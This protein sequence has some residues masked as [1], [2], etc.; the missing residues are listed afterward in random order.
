[1]PIVAYMDGAHK[2]TQSKLIMSTIVSYSKQCPLTSLVTMVL[3]FMRAWVGPVLMSCTALTHPVFGF[4]DDTYPPQKMVMSPYRSPS[5]TAK[6]PDEQI[7]ASRQHAVTVKPHLESDMSRARQAS[8]ALLRTNGHATT[9]KD[10][11]GEKS[12]AQATVMRESDQVPEAKN[13]VGQELAQTSVAPYEMVPEM[14]QGTQIQPSATVMPIKPI[15][16][17]GAQQSPHYAYDQIMRWASEVGISMLTYS[18]DHL[19]RDKKYNAQ[20]FSPGAWQTVEEALFLNK[21]SPFSKLDKT[22]GNS[23]AMTVD[24]PKALSMDITPNGKIWWLSVPLMAEVKSGTA[25]KRFGY[26]VKFGV[27]PIHEANGVRFM[28]DEIVIQAVEPASRP[29]L[30]GRR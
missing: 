10:V 25:R 13:K 7:P 22:H 30:R 21:N 3:Q 1:M 12:L 29:R 5:T 2:K 27:L 28:V 6:K 18:G 20:Y 11:I 26:R 24:W 14:G 19:A 8:D 16:P 9:S 17:T 23:K 15:K 4:F